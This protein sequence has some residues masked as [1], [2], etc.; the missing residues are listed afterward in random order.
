MLLVSFKNECGDIACI[1]WFCIGATDMPHTH[2]NLQRPR[3]VSGNCNNAPVLPLQIAQK[4]SFGGALRNI[5]ALFR[6]KMAEKPHGY[7]VA[8]VL[9][10]AATV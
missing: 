2:L 10:I 1:S 5:H 7:C 3:Y 8:A 4:H 9:G 6:A